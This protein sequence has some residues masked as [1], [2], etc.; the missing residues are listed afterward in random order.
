MPI[1]RRATSATITVKPK[2]PTT[3][4]VL[5]NHCLFLGDFTME[6]KTVAEKDDLGINLPQA[7]LNQ[8]IAKSNYFK[9]GKAVIIGTRQKMV[10][11]H[12]SV[13]KYTEL[14]VEATG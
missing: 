1:S 3:S 11:N 4:R 7:K 6:N 13:A 14:L 5:T 8:H 9:V 10:K 2:L 12:K